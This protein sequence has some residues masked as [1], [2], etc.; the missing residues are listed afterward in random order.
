VGF[1]YGELWHRVSSGAQTETGTGV[2]SI[3]N[4]LLVIGL[5]KAHNA[6]LKIIILFILCL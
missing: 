6:F 3:G 2:V 4:S 1:G 5:K